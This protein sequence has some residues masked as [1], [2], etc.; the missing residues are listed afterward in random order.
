MK[1]Y[2]LVFLAI[3]CFIPVSYCFAYSGITTSTENGVPVTKTDYRGFT[4]KHAEWF[5]SFDVTSGTFVYNEA[6]ESA[7]E[8]GAI[9]VSTIFDGCSLS[10]AVTTH[11]STNVT[12]QIEGRVE[13]GLWTLIAQDITTGTDTVG[14]SFPITT[15]FT[16]L[17][18]GAS[19][20]GDT[21][22]NI[23]TVEGDCVNEKNK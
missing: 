13:G 17:R 10:V 3:L 12:V 4:R 16:G 15:Y 9:D 23:L 5:T 18:V 14:E 6:G 1:K 2:L 22:T 11:N 8:S 7:N 19:V 20:T 21:G